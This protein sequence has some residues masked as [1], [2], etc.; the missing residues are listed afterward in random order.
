MQQSDP[1]EEAR[2]Q[3]V[4]HW[5][6]GATDAMVA[7][8]AIMRAQQILMARL[9]ALLKPFDMTLPRYE[10]LMVLYLSRRGALPLGKLGRRLQV[11]PTSVTSLVDGLERLG[12]VRRVADVEDRRT[13]LAEITPQGREAAAA[14]TRLLNKEQYGTTPLESAGLVAL[15]EALRPLRNAADELEPAPATDGRATRRRRADQPQPVR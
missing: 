6:T 15:H 3:W 14:A 8:T 4:K 1:I 11:H 5:G 2:R 7:V 13:T 9:N 12:Y 10:A